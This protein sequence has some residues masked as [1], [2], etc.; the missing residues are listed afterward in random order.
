[1]SVVSVPRTARIGADIGK[2]DVEGFLHRELVRSLGELSRAGFHES[3]KTLLHFILE[4][5]VKVW[6]IQ[7][8][9][10]VAHT[11][12]ISFVR[13]HQSEGPRHLPGARSDERQRS[14]CADPAER[15]S[16]PPP[17]QRTRVG[18]PLRDATVLNLVHHETAEEK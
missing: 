15:T 4:L 11:P 16:G 7:P 8:S 3:D 10:F 1:M 9:Q 18:E 14:L 13:H 5:S 17:L 6:I 12:K 2:L